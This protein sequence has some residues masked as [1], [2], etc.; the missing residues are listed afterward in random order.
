MKKAFLAK[1][2]GGA[3]SQSWVQCVRLQVKRPRILF[4]NNLLVIYRHP[5]L[6]R[7]A[8]VSILDLSAF[9]RTSGLV[10]ASCSHKC[11]LT[12][13]IQ[14]PNCL[15]M[16]YKARTMRQELH[17]ISG[18][19]LACIQCLVNSKGQDSK[20]ILRTDHN[21][22]KQLSIWCNL[23]TAD[24]LDFQMEKLQGFTTD[25]WLGRLGRLGLAPGPRPRAVM[26]SADPC[27]GKL[28]HPERALRRTE[29]S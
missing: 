14:H 8:P 9:C 17:N 29:E 27:S 7:V 2:H 5:S 21:F 3:W 18:Q 28:N 19:T 4:K 16:E 13:S 15:N 25:W 26:P 12:N 20:K 24:P 11:W 23:T 10:M 22:W 6:S 1:F